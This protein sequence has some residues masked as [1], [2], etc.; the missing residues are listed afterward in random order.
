MESKGCYLN[1]HD[2]GVL[3]PL[4][5]STKK[6]IFAPGLLGNECAGWHNLKTLHFKETI[7]SG[8]F[9]MVISNMCFFAALYLL[10][11]GSRELFCSDG[12]G[13]PLHALL[14][15]ALGQQAACQLWFHF[16]EEIKGSWCEVMELGEPLDAFFHSQIIPVID[17]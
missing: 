4:V 6:I 1:P 10:Q 12:G 3:E 16:E 5:G 17:I 8:N 11:D 7:I 14:E 15:G 2:S 13:D 9:S